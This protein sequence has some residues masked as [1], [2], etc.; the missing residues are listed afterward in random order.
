[1]S[2]ACMKKGIQRSTPGRGKRRLSI[3]PSMIL[4]RTGMAHSRPGTNRKERAVNFDTIR[5][6]PVNIDKFTGFF[7]KIS[8]PDISVTH[9]NSTVI[10]TNLSA[11]DSN[12]TEKN[13]PAPHLPAF[14][15]KWAGLP[16]YPRNRVQYRITG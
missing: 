8:A 12:M 11:D 10:S 6:N 13:F 15:M 14:G 2:T 5:N 16:A 1:M 7:D 9:C 4:S 3:R